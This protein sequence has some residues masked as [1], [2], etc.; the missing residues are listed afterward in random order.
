MTSSASEF[1]YVRPN[2]ALVTGASAG[3][4]AAMARAWLE[5]GGTSLRPAALPV[6]IR[7]GASSTAMS[8][9][10]AWMS[11]WRLPSALGL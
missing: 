3:L 4:G 1:A 2:V 6:P 5:K 8:S 7:V 10:C 11:R 9:H